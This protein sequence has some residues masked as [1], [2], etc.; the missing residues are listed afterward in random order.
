MKSNKMTIICSQKFYDLGH[1]PVRTV[2]SEKFVHGSSLD[3][4][5]HVYLHDER[6]IK[7]LVSISC[8][9]YVINIFIRISASIKTTPI[10]IICCE[11]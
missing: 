3:T 6:D 10:T 11:E 5:T 1:L 2:S 7:F 4:H 8:E 9:I